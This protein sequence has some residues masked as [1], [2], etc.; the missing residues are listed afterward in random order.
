MVASVCRSNQEDHAICLAEREL[1]G[2]L[3][4]AMGLD[5][6]QQNEIE[7]DAGEALKKQPSLWQVLYGC[8]S[9]R[10]DFPILS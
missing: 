2:Q 7:R 9:H 4:Q 6:T 1:L 5:P 8:F 10:F 3:A